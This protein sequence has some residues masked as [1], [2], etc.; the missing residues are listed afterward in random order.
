VWSWDITFLA[1]SIRGA[2]YW[3]YLVEDIYSRKLVSWEIHENETAEHASVLIRKT[4]LTEG[5]HKD[6]LVLHS[7]NSSSMKG[8]TILATLQKLGIVP[9]FSRPLVSDD[10]SYSES[11]FR[12]L[13]YTPV[14]PTK[15]FQ[16]IEATCQWMDQ[17]VQWYNGEYRQSAIPYV[18]PNQ[19]HENIDT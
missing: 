10:N 17:F 1:S 4:C 5:I 13:K 3:L 2:F 18:T 16:N 19:R 9:S 11:L 14:Y 15:P 8:A 12:T 6:S 7:D